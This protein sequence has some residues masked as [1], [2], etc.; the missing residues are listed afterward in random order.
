[1]YREA[2]NYRKNSGLLALNVILCWA[3]TDE[4]SR[5]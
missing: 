1:M 5:R 3:I 4:L 2:Q